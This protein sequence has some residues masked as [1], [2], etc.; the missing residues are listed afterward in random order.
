MRRKGL[1]AVMG[2]TLSIGLCM[3][4][5]AASAYQPGTYTGTAQ[6]F[7]GDV[8]VTVEV[9]E[10]AVT[11]VSITGS[12]ETPEVGGAAIPELEQQVMAAQGDDVEGSCS[13]YWALQG[14]VG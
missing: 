1:S 13:K 10:D 5:L 7:G 3:T 14:A 9:S 12:D 6:G 4:A 8:E 2:L 11:S